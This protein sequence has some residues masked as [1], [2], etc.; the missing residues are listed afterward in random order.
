MFG[1]KYSYALWLALQTIKECAAIKEK[2]K[3][4][5]ADRNTKEGAAGSGS[6]DAD[7]SSTPGGGAAKI[8]GEDGASAPDEDAG[9]DRVD[10]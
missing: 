5:I 9:Q 2:V 8:P 7:A 6:C 10:N 1:E 4:F 3:K